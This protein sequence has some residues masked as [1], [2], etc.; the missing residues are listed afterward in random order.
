MELCLAHLV[1]G[2][3]EKEAV[4]VVVMVVVVVEEEEEEE[5][6]EAVVVVEVR[7]K[8][9]KQ[10]AEAVTRHRGHAAHLRHTV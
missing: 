2:V 10:V 1:A 8:L 7:L 6:E 3:M 5:E 4:V 9:L